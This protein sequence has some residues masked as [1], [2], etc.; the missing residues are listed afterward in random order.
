MSSALFGQ[1]E[2]S[3]EAYRNSDITGS[4]QTTWPR[5]RDTMLCVLFAKT[6]QQIKNLQSRW[7]PLETNGHGPWIVYK[8]TMFSSGRQSDKVTIM[9]MRPPIGNLII[10]CERFVAI[11]EDQ[12]CRAGLGCNE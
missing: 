7:E 5:S 6:I 11:V 8:R 1:L 9:I 10:A 12:G 4:I 3:S 2:L